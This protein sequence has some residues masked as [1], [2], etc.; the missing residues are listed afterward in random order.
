M[1]EQIPDSSSP[2]PTTSPISLRARAAQLAQ[3]LRDELHKAVIGQDEVIDGV[4]TALIAG[5]HVLIEG[6]PG[7]GKTLLVRALARCFG[8]EFSRI[9]F[10]P[11]LMPSDV[12]GHAVYDMQSEQF[13]LRKGPVFTN[14]LLADEI[15]RAP[16]KTQA[17]LLEVMQER[18]VTLEGRALA[19]PQPF[20]VMATQNPI[21][22]EGTYPLPEAELDRFMLMLRMDYPQADE[23]LELVRQV[24]RSARAD[25]LDVSALRQLVQARDV[26]ALQKIAS[27]LPLDEQ[28][29]D[30]AVR[31]VRSTRSWPGLALGAG[32][33]ASIALVR[34]GRARALLRG[35]EFVTPDD[36]KDCA[37]AVLRH[38]VR[39]SAELDIEGLSVDQVLHQ[40]LDQVPAPRA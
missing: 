2:A 34:G 20:M 30:Y 19:V 22:Q 26:Q 15:N 28:V 13:K 10:T 9:Q 21:E 17:A 3:A 35:G 31:L 32:P 27:E 18:Q 11:D 16:A 7:L 33:R 25:M 29:L 6:V 1:S 37:R 14:L 36:I 12:T 4:L 23:E 5:G 39:L 8:G 38:R 40:L 24:S